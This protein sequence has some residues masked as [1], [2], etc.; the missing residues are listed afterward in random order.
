MSENFGRLG[1]KVAYSVIVGSLALSLGIGFAGAG[2][3]PSA[4]TIVNSLTPKR[5]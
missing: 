5:R 4:A 3:Q 2:E 1:L